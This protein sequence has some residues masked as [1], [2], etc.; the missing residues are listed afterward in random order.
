M[1]NNHTKP[2]TQSTASLPKQSPPKI[3]KKVSRYSSYL[4]TAVISGA[5][6]FVVNKIADWNLA[7]I[8]D[9][10]EKMVD[11]FNFSLIVTIIINIIFLLYDERRFYFLGRT[12]L[13]IITIIVLYNLVTI[14]PL[15]FSAVNINWLNIVAR[16]AFWLGMAGSVIG[17]IVRSVKFGLG[18]NIHY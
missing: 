13:D 17:I 15:D 3:S 10:W 7:F 12:I 6:L 18:K 2:V 16:L 9:D 11:I 8:T 1:K 5:M 4:A 14:F